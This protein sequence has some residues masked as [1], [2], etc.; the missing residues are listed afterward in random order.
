MIVLTHVKGHGIGCV[1]GSIKNL[2]IGA[3][4]GG[5]SRTC[6]WAPSQVRFCAATD[7]HPERC[8]GARVQ[9]MGALRE[10]LPAWPLPRHGGQH[11]MDR[12]GCRL[13]GAPR[14][15]HALWRVQL[16]G[17]HLSGNRR[18]H[19][20]ACWHGQGRGTGPGGFINMAIDIAPA[21]TAWAFPI[22]RSCRT[23]G[24]CL[25]GPVALDKARWT[26][27]SPHRDS[28]S[29]PRLCAIE[30]GSHKFSAAAMVHFDDFSKRSRSRPACS[31]AGSKEYRMVEVPRPPMPASG[32]S[33]QRSPGPSSGH[34]CQR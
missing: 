34:L 11:R 32:L 26:K 5:A 19:G 25:H 28:R 1:G 16:S 7:F 3:Q 8:K 10:H 9:A 17:G 12:H 23:W 18:G 31:T 27:R 13:S 14:R 6:T 33:D 4:S 2:G 21:V 15:H 20:D 30:P 29:P 22:C 24:L